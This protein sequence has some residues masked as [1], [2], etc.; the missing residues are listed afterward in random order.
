MVKTPS[1]I[2]FI[3][4]TEKLVSLNRHLLTAIVIG[5]VCLTSLVLYL[6]IDK[7]FNNIQERIEQSLIRKGMTLVNNNAIAMQGMAE[8]NAITAVKALVSL[9]VKQDPEIV[10]GEY[11]DYEGVI[12]A[13]SI[14]QAYSTTDQ[15][16]GLRKEKISLR[17]WSTSRK[18]G[19]YT[20]INTPEIQLIEFAAPV[21]SEEKIL[22]TIR[23]GFDMRA[24]KQEIEQERADVF[25]R[26]YQF[27]AII[28]VLGTFFL[29][30]GVRLSRRQANEITNPLNE[31]TNAANIISEGNYGS[32]I[33]VSSND[34]VGILAENFETMR[35]VIQEYTDDLEKKVSDRTKQLEEAQNKALDNAH[36]AGMAEVATGTLHNIGN[37]LNSVVTSATVVQHSIDTMNFS[38]FEN[39]NNLLKENIK[40][41]ED[42]IKYDKKGKKLFEYYLEV[43]EN[44]LS[45]K[46]YI[47]KHLLR[48]QEKLDVISNTIAAQ[49]SYAGNMSGNFQD[50]EIET[51]ID[52]ALT[53]SAGTISKY[54]IDVRKKIHCNPAIKVDKNKVIQIFINLISNAAHA[55]FSNPPSTPRLLSIAVN[56]HESGNFVSV[57]FEDNGCGI[58][59]DI[60]NKIFNY[61]FTTKEEG[62]GFGLHS[63]ANF[64]TEMGGK[65]NVRSKGEGKG[66]CFYMTFPSNIEGG[67]AAA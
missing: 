43:G 27:L 29:I 16:S 38:G 31:L 7:T 5:M 50:I 56:E 51:I 66:A 13:E 11:L 44:M 22:G 48:L 47:D 2:A 15:N 37:V 8:D 26:L 60:K 4:I 28:I 36:K 39:A 30:V 53:I 33:K 54:D 18:T 9:T 45:G 34:E 35:N 23:F 63:C 52:D 21:M 25:K 1:K 12:W 64:L 61:G 58:P 10:Y 20:I 17:H 24:T 32:K 67:N 57:E 62:H 46:K 59:E 6:S 65:M 42:F 14:A 40:N 41:I 19:E 3:S 49:Q 55:M